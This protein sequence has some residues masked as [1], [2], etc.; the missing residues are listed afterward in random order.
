M[1]TT[2]DKLKIGDKFYYIDPGEFTALMAWT[3]IGERT[4]RRDDGVQDTWKYD[5]VHYN[6]QTVYLMESKT[7]IDLI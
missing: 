6:T 3:K 5:A 7:V 2:F 1:R 4:V